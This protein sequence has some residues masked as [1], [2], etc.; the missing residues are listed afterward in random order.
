MNYRTIIYLDTDFP[1]SEEQVVYL[2]TIAPVIFENEI[3]KIRKAYDYELSKK[4]KEKLTDK[5]AAITGEKI[6]ELRLAKDWTLDDL[7][8]KIGIG[9]SALS[10]LENRTRK[11]KLQKKTVI[12]VMQVLDPEYLKE[13]T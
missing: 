11:N 10:H 1:L 9:R 3:K 5:Y 2:N 8:H 13:T 12:R 4:Q 6:K 7:A